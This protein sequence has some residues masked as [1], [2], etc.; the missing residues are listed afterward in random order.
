MPRII[1]VIEAPNQGPNDMVARVPET[2]AGDFRLG[3]QVIVRE[4]QTAVFYRD[5]KSLDS[6]PA[7]AATRSRRPTCPLLSSLL[8]LRLPAATTCSRPKSISSICASLPT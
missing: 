5:G 6:F 3:S 8:Q 7:R 1:D 4:S 2:G